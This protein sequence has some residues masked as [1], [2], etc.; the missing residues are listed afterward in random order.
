MKRLLEQRATKRGYLWEAVIICVSQIAMAFEAYVIPEHFWVAV[1]IRPSYD[2]TCEYNQSGYPIR[3][4][5]PR[6]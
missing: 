5:R 2:N 6:L 3:G 1:V 4:V